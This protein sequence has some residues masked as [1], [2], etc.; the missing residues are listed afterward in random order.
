MRNRRLLIVLIVVG[1]ITLSIVLNS[2]IFSVR[3][4]SA[5]CYNADDEMLSRA[6]LDGCGIK[7]GG[8]IFSL[9][10]EKVAAAVE[11]KVP[12]AKVINIE[13]KFPDSVFINYVKVYEYLRVK[14]GGTYYFCGNDLTV[15][16]SS[17]NSG[18]TEDIIELRIASEI[19]SLE[20]GKLF[21]SA[22]PADSTI[23][24]ALLSGLECLGY[25]REIVGMIDFIDVTRSQYVFLGMASGVKIEL[26]GT[27]NLAEKIRIA[28]SIY[29]LDATQKTRGTIII[30]DGDG[31]RGSWSPTDR[32]ADIT[33]KT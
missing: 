28:L 8:S 15:M 7:E 27:A 14:K 21:A 18:L 26:Q 9:N 13:R 2:V 17:E 4:V 23:I 3:K 19:T 33:G 16:R 22:D 25:Q 24:K 6:V 29:R 12:Q 1:A 10:E 20:V 5:Y 11:E 30:P 31:S 32:Y